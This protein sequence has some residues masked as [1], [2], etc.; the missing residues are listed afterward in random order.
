MIAPL[1]AIVGPTASGKSDFSMQLAQRY[2]G[3]IICADSRTVYK[4]MDIGTAKP[5]AQD[6]KLIRHHLIDIREPNQFFSAAEF[7]Q[8]ANQAIHDIW[9]R[10]RLPIMVGGTGL[11]IDSVLF[12]YDFGRPADLEIRKKMNE[13]SIGQLQ[14]MCKQKNITLPQNA[15]NKRHLVRALELGG[16]L[17]QHKQFRENTLVAGLTTDKAILRARIRERALKMQKLGILHEAQHLAVRYGW[18]SEAMKGN[19]YRNLKE[20][21][22]GHK[23]LEE[24]ISDCIQSDI[25]LAKRQMTW[26]K[27]NHHIVWGTVDEITAVVD[28]FVKTTLLQKDSHLLQ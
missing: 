4:G 1:V 16:L 20:F 24:A 18:N 19:M 5:S 25:H 6:Q 23:T 22:K 15:C 2:N 14:E 8:L 28:G 17:Q 13:M 9:E 10:Q 12:D 11:Y 7:K 26:F 27:R 3:E 21:I